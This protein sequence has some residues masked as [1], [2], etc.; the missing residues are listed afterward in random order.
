[1]I[2]CY[3]ML[4]LFYLILKMKNKKTKTFNALKTEQTIKQMNTL[5]DGF[6]ITYAKIS[7]NNLYNNVVITF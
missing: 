6:K 1:M 3:P 7:E 2:L 4:Y 5:L